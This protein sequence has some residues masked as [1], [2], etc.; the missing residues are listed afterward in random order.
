MRIAPGN[1]RLFVIA[2]I[3]LSG[4]AVMAADANHGARTLRS[5]GAPAA[6]WLTALRHRPA[7]T[8]RRLRRS[9]VSQISPR[10]RSPSSFSTRIPRCRIFRWAETRPPISLLTSGRFAN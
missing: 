10:K 3:G 6:T 5:A 7:P 8:F 9:R 4:S 2:A 1:A